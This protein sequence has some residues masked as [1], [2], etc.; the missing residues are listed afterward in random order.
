MS[1]AA[2]PIQQ[3]GQ[4]AGFP[5]AI[6][7]KNSGKIRKNLKLAKISQFDRHRCWWFPVRLSGAPQDGLTAPAA[8]QRNYDK[9]GEWGWPAP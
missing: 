2:R 5:R 7:G 1:G 4:L 6:P 8:E 3:L 9:R